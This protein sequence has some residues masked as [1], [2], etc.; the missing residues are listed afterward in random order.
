MSFASRMQANTCATV[1]YSLQA[2]TANLLQSWLSS[3]I[4]APSVI[5]LLIPEAGSEHCFALRSHILGIQLQ[6][7]SL[8]LT[9]T[10]KTLEKIP[11]SIAQ[12]GPKTRGL[13]RKFRSDV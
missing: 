13:C 9:L 10:K 3:L 2:G 8:S 6:L 1:Q 4:P 7:N 5:Q 12:F 11:A